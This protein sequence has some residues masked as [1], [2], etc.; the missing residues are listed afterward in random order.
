MINIIN[1]Q[2]NDNLNKMRLQN[3]FMIMAT[4]PSV[5]EDMVQLEC[6]YTA[7]GRANWYNPFRKLME[8][9]KWLNLLLAYES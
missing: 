9:L 4:I 1:H 8:L 7:G 3:T 5:E 6:S 2:G